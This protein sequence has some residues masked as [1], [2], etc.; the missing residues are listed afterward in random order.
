[1][2]LRYALYRAKYVYGSRLPLG[3][4]VD[5]SLELS[6]HCNMRCSYCYHSDQDGLPF[7]K[8]Y[9]PF[10]VAQKII[11]QAGALGVHSLKFNWKGESTANPNF[12][13]I[14]RY[15]KMI[16]D[17]YQ[18]STFIDR[19]LN[20]NF[21]FSHRREDVFDAMATLTK[22]KVS[23]DS[24]R[25]EV[26]ETQRAK[27]VWDR[28]YKNIDLFYNWPGRDNEMVIQAVRT[29]LNYDEDIEQEVKRRWPS[30]SVSIRDVVAGR[31]ETEED[32]FHKKRDLENR[33]TCR[34]AH[35]RIIFNKD[36]KAFP[37]CP[38]VPETLLLGDINKQS[39]KEIFNGK[40]AKFLRETLKD[41]RAFKIYDAC[42]NCSS[43]ESYKGH[44]PNWVS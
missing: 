42:K 44:K 17:K 39:L 6:S 3:A 23:F 14:I 11:N 37:C 34:Q 36:G 2:D 9:M 1:M 18:G 41:K 27:G 29:K 19:I 24:F 35:V 32:L 8:N 22:V 12:A 38:D 25:K 28:T 43:F 31:V 15:S 20:S 10:D 21:K 26:F 7:T 4:P 16:R 30:A 13:K 5:V 40:K 33:V